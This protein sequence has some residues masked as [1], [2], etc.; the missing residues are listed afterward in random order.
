M[1]ALPPVSR[2]AMLRG[3]GRVT[4]SELARTLG[5]GELGAASGFPCAV[6]EMLCMRES[7]TVGVLRWTEIGCRCSDFVVVLAKRK[8]GIGRVKSA[9]AAPVF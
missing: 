7:Q 1:R 6:N 3:M 8:L 4:G 2:S 5:M 9:E